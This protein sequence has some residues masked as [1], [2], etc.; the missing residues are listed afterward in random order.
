MTSPLDTHSASAGDD[1]AVKGSSDRTFGIVFAVFFALI[2]LW[3]LVRGEPARA[4]ALVIAAA[5][6]LAALVRPRLLA[7]LN[8]LWTKF[9]LLLHKITNPVIMAAVFY[10]AV[11]PTA[12]VLR[13]MGKDPLRRRID[14]SATTYWI[15]RQPPGPEPQSMTQQF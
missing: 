7:S 6:L 2:G 1:T 15:D 3:P 12:L 5:F 9:G 10:G 14:R 13:M 4:W 8:R 11:T